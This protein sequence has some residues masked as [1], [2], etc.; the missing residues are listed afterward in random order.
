M[1]LFSFA[2]EVLLDN[3]AK[4][5]EKDGEGETALMWAVRMEENN[6]LTT[7]IERGKIQQTWQQQAE[8]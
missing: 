1:C 5:D 8:S 4:I 2:V 6:V 3:G 7:L